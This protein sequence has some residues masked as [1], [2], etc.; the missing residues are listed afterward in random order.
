MV[1]EEV[2]T[3]LP[4]D[5]IIKPDPISKPPAQL[6]IAAEK[7]AAAA[8]E[9]PSIGDGDATPRKGRWRLRSPRSSRRKIKQQEDTGGVVL[10]NKITPIKVKSPK[11]KKSKK[12]F[13]FRNIKKNDSNAT[14][15]VS[16]TANKVEDMK[17]KEKEKDEPVEEPVV[18]QREAAEESNDAAASPT[19]RENS[20]NTLDTFESVGHEK[21]VQDNDEEKNNEDAS[22]VVA[23]DISAAPRK[24]EANDEE[25]ASVKSS[26]SARS[27]KSISS[28]KSFI[29]NL[30]PSKS[31]E[32]IDDQ[33]DEVSKE[34]PAGSEEDTTLAFKEESAKDITENTNK[35]AAAAATAA[36][37]TDTTLVV[38]DKA[39][40][41]EEA[42]MKAQETSIVKHEEEGPGKGSWVKKVSLSIGGRKTS[43]QI[44]DPMST[45]A[46]AMNGALDAVVPNDEVL[47][48][49]A[50]GLDDDNNDGEEESRDYEENPTHLFMYLQQRAWGLAVTQLKKNPEEARVWNYR[51]V[52]SE[53]VSTSTELVVHDGSSPDEHK[54]RWKLLPLHAAIVLGAPTEIIQDI[55]S[56]YPEASK[57]SDE[58]GSL[59]VHLAASRLDIDPE[60][61]KV[62]L[63]LFGT[64]PESIELE[65]RKGRNPPELAKLARRRREIEVD[66]KLN[67]RLSAA[68]Q[69]SQAS[70]SNADTI[71]ESIDDDGDGD[72]G[73]DN[74]DDDDDGDGDEDTHDGDDADGDGDDD[75]GDDDDDDDDDG[76]GD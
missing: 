16:N 31:K 15:K 8:A 25:A 52:K 14:E 57:K 69:V 66:R 33:K 75:G 19:V 72:D 61:E 60:G 45:L 62:V 23:A 2:E 28:K 55:I 6:D 29:S 51:K 18:E 49:Q 17:E 65:D 26:K 4:A 46:G 73:D 12:I 24:L 74:D 13:S 38:D 56:A 48:E 44:S 39:P 10:V 64:Y 47:T 21:H 37:A 54:Y 58:R 1:Y 63:Q 50:K 76:E 41:T 9:G 7:A 30:L 71:K 11:P 53:G 59:P 70:I 36:D 3:V 5:F 22:G 20:P 42:L 27:K 40:K 34:V 35:A 43:F 67:A 68:S 32:V